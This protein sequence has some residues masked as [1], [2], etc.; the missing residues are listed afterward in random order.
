MKFSMMRTMNRIPPSAKIGKL[1]WDPSSNHDVFMFM[2]LNLFMMHTAFRLGEIV[3][4]RSGEIM[5]ITFACV[6][7]VINGVLITDPSAAQLRRLSPGRDK[8][9]VAPS[10]SKADQT[11]EIHC[12]FPV[13]LTF[14]DHMDNPC[15]LYTSPSPR[16]S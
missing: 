2:C 11:G 7:W 5:F 14:E 12:P 15:L 8:A 9:L 4:H 16:D 6:T 13:S 1:T 10:R 3:A